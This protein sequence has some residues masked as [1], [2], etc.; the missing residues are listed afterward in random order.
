MFRSKLFLAFSFFSVFTLSSLC[1]PHAAFATDLDSVGGLS[2]ESVSVSASASASASGV[3]TDSSYDEFVSYAQESL[4]GMPDPQHMWDEDESSI[5][6]MA[7]SPYW[8]NESGTKSFY[9]GY[10]RLYAS[11]ALFVIDVSEHQGKID[12][13][14][15]KASGVDAVILRFGYGWGNLDR[16]FERNLSEVRRL[17]IP[18]GLYMYSYAYDAQTA[19]YE[20]AWTAEVLDKYGTSGMKLPMYYDLEN[21]GSW[22]EN[23]TTYYVPSTVSQYEA[24]VDSYVSTMA[25]RG[26]DNVNVYSYRNYLQ[27]VLD[28]PSIWKITSWVAAYSSEV[29]IDNP[30]YSGQYG[31]Q[32]SSSGHVDGIAGN[33]DCNAFSAFDYLDVELLPQVSLDDGTYY[34]NSQ[35]KDSSGI[36]FAEGDIEQGSAIQLGSYEKSANQ[37]FELVAQDSGGYAIR[38]EASGLVLDVRNGEA[39]NGAIVQQFVPNGS[40]AQ[41]WY[42]RDSGDGYFIQSALGN[43]VLDVSGASTAD[44]TPITLYTPNGSYA[45]K[46]M[47]GEISE[48]PVDSPQRL[49]SAID[50]NMVIDLQSALA[51]N[52]TAVQLYSWN[53]SDAQLFIFREVG[54]G[55][56]EIESASSGKVIEV[57]GGAT[58]NGSKI[59][60]YTRNG[61]RSQHWTVRN[62]ANGE[63]TLISVNT[64]KALDVPNGSAINGLQLQIFDDNGTASQ[65]WSITPWAT[66]RQRID[67]FASE[68]AGTISPGVYAIGTSFSERKVVDVANGSHEDAA[69]VQLFGSNASSAQRWE[70]TED[71]DGYLTIKNVG[72]GKVLD[73]VGANNASGTNVQQ[74]K[75]NNSY[76]QKWIAVDSN[77]GNVILHSALDEQLVLDVA[78]GRASDGTNID[79]YAINET[80]AQK[81]KLYSAEIVDTS[82]SSIENGTYELITGDGRVIDVPSASTND[83]VNMQ[84]FAR[85]DTAAQSFYLEKLENGT[86]SIRAIVSGKYL[87]ADKGDIVPGGTVAQW[88]SGVD[89]VE[90]RCWRIVD[91]GDGTFSVINAANG[92][93][94]GLNDNLLVTVSE[95][96]DRAISWR[97]EESDYIGS[98]E[99]LN[100]QAASQGTVVPDGI[101]SISS[102][103]SSGMLLDVSGG[104]TAN[105]GNVQLYEGNN[106][107]AQKWEVINNGDGFIRI[108]NV[109][110]GK[111]LD[112]DSGVAESGRNVWQY[113][114]NGTRA[115]L[116]CPI[117]LNDKSV[118]LYSALGSSLV[119]DVSGGGIYNGVNVQ[120]FYVNSSSAQQF[121]FS[122][123]S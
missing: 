102:G 117:V 45:Q 82:S 66:K 100:R 95:N 10:G 5:G 73:V 78:G 50:G 56:Y 42:L 1:A 115:Q 109:R 46:F 62:E 43:W 119:L 79:V 30:Y 116:W 58:S 20:A 68:N 111:L 89:G 114:A 2:E 52:G 7:S 72:S 33:V 16:E 99:E 29:G 28:S 57:A 67:A 63:V 8:D 18:Y 80:S 86:Y 15:V 54:N 87:D 12:W 101:Y 76:A 39:G 121:W 51:A 11:P 107:D 74:Y 24:I 44:G 120:L 19:S 40:D 84:L 32:Y 70:I 105:G 85:N 25:S 27:T 108:R 110:S 94:L 35:L 71:M 90:Q 75:P 91:R 9:D 17:G 38:N 93:Y 113:E 14:R 53:T 59:S 36:E 103:L 64:G 61:T 77:D 49:S 21:W 4:S 37:R 55:V 122:R 23:G 65:R 6:L 98:G 48:V 60:Q 83:G 47:L 31:W 88:G 81:F 104:S 13:D 22:S 97:L 112:V 118:V 26:Y 96:D 92:L 3:D 69:N 34:L 123:I 106:T 41:R